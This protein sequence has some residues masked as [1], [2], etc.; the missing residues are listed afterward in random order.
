MVVQMT[1][2]EDLKIDSILKDFAISFFNFCVI[3]EDIPIPIRK[4]SE[5][6][7][8]S[9]VLKLANYFNGM[10]PK[11]LN[12]L[13]RIG[14]K[15]AYN[16][17]KLLNE[18]YSVL[19][20]IDNIKD[21][22]VNEK[23][24]FIS[25]LSSI[26]ELQVNSF[27]F[28]K[29]TKEIIGE[30]EN[31]EFYI[32]NNKGREFLDAGK[33][34][35][36]VYENKSICFNVIP[37]LVKHKRDFIDEMELSF[38]NTGLIPIWRIPKNKCSSDNK[39]SLY[40]K[41]LLGLLEID[42]FE[43]MKYQNSEFL[44]SPKI[45]LVEFLN[46]LREK[47]KSDHLFKVKFCTKSSRKDKIF[48]K[49]KLDV[50]NGELKFD[51][52]TKSNINED[53]MLVMYNEIRKAKIAKALREFFEGIYQW[54]LNGDFNYKPIEL[55]ELFKTLIEKTLSVEEK[56]G[57]LFFDKY[58]YRDNALNLYVNRSL[59]D[60]LKKVKK[61]ER[62]EFEKSFNLNKNFKL[63]LKIKNLKALFR[64][65]EKES[66]PIFNLKPVFLILS[67]SLVKDEGR[68]A[69]NLLTLETKIRIRFIPYTL[70]LQEENFRFYLVER[71]DNL[72][73][74]DV[75]DEGESV[76][77]DTVIE[78]INMI[79]KEWKYILFDTE[80]Y[81]KSIK[82]NELLKELKSRYLLFPIYLKKDFTGNR[83]S[84]GDG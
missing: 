73:L 65:I 67:V 7:I 38:L 5:D 32:L 2:G 49:V 11:L 22:N 51:F 20:R 8:L 40:R 9:T 62:D 27:K 31:G 21:R 50:T 19:D 44:F 39:Y 4:Y 72:K 30:V 12:T 56:G 33:F 36:I 41:F 43:I 18:D 46:N 74:V 57:N 52:E 1:D 83:G 64:E 42:P 24:E 29:I 53:E 3:F 6:K 54:L 48:F 10:T 77:L 60:I 28:E 55:L 84:E 14:K 71:I 37:D 80:K 13:L 78:T 16:L 70:R 68:F 79:R 63:V 58:D 35:R 47:V 34:Y 66:V 59:P 69:L 17:L 15:V 75:C 26:S 76:I 25:R 81:I 23:E 61:I 45:D 82:V